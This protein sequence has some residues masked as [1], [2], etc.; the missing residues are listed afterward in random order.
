M[1]GFSPLAGLPL[2]ADEDVLI[3]DGSIRPRVI[4]TGA[5]VLGSP[6]AAV[7]GPIQLSAIV[8]G[9]PV[10]AAV[11]LSSEQ[12]FA[13]V[14]IA[15]AAPVLGLP[16]AVF[17]APIPVNGIVTSAPVI[18][19]P[20]DTPGSIDAYARALQA[21]GLASSNSPIF[22][23]S[24]DGTKYFVKEGSA[25]GGP[26][27]R[28][29]LATPWNAGTGTLV[30]SSAF[31]LTTAYS[32]KDFQLSDD[33][34]HIAFL[35]LRTVLDDLNRN[36]NEFSLHL[37][38]L[39]QPFVTNY[40]GTAS[41]TTSASGYTFVRSVV[42]NTSTSAANDITAFRFL[43]GKLYTV[44]KTPVNI[45]KI[46]RRGVGSS[47]FSGLG[48]AQNATISVE[49]SST[50]FNGPSLTFL[51][52][53]GSSRIYHNRAVYDP[54]TLEQLEVSSQTFGANLRYQLKPDGVVIVVPQLAEI[55]TDTSVTIQQE[56]A[57]AV[58]SLLAPA[59]ILGAAAFN[60]SHVLVSGALLTGAPVIS[61]AGF[62]QDHALGS[63]PI[64]TG[65]PEL[66]AAVFQ[67][68]LLP[69]VDLLAGAPEL[70]VTFFQD[71]R[72]GAESVSTGPP[73]FATSEIGQ[74][75]VLDPDAL[76]SPAPAL[77]QTDIS[78]NHDLVDPAEILT[79][80]PE[81]PAA[82]F[83]DHLL[84]TDD[85]DAEPPE[86][87][88]GPLSQQHVLAAESV[89]TS[90]PEIS[91]EI[92][93]DHALLTDEV[94]VSPP[95]MA[96]AV[97]Q[98]HNLGAEALSTGPP[99]TANTNAAQ[100]H[101]LDAGDALAFAFALGAPKLFQE[102]NVSGV[103]SILAAAPVLSKASPGLILTSAGS[104]L[105]SGASS[106]SNRVE[107]KLAAETEAAGISAAAV[108][109]DGSAQSEFQLET[110]S[111]GAAL[112]SGATSATLDV[113]G[114]SVSQ[115]ATEGSFFGH[116]VTTGISTGSSQSQGNASSSLV[117]GGLVVGAVRLDA[118]ASG[119]S[120]L[121][122]SINGHVQT[123]GY[124]DGGILLFGNSNGRSVVR[125]TS[126]PLVTF[127]V[128]SE[129]GSLSKEGGASGLIGLSCIASGQV[130]IKAEAHFFFPIAAASKGARVSPSRTVS[131]GEL[132]ETNV[133]FNSG[134]ESLVS[135]VGGQATYALP[136]NG[137]A[138]FV[139][140]LNSES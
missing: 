124:C 133:S 115:A 14:G 49:V 38:S 117:I 28:Y 138:S 65:A 23:F 52:L 47:A 58:T 101:S 21:K 85:A 98:G 110:F 113:G 100:E 62:V 36:A 35:M 86:I 137:G 41:S 61:T 16:G 67:D 18:A 20:I 43:G 90:A 95:E 40:T 45:S 140:I 127:A 42:L 93:Q 13:P 39:D 11:A 92:F 94:I 123:S 80:A 130:Y 135:L 66:P 132:A 120:S 7:A 27:S 119:E 55:D 19:G 63:V 99:S 122:V 26:P 97:L 139:Q 22:Q 121:G 79:G 103:A 131:I 128:A 10:V 17:G 91:A 129:G 15:A 46:Q 12:D 102:H 25:A 70:P 51:S 30:N 8:T 108:R 136:I 1:L 76:F 72:T 114:G 104:I 34:N 33:G 9:T 64:D 44:Q 59:P 89:I 77:A 32:V 83:Q 24:L 84:P 75:H 48:V 78:Q 105:I 50:S 125:G 111:V 96:A 82:V 5:P 29:D 71:H 112:V 126:N 37:Y 118:G 68:H 54:L 88:F 69:P 57:S 3:A 87:G 60:Q 4:A 31:N 53:D 116:F 2:G 81:L 107:G 73:D 134:D 74:D 56:G 6:A 109:I 106:A